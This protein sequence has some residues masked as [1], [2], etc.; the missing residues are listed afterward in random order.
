MSALP[1]TRELRALDVVEAVPAGCF[2]LLVMGE[3]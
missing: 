1:A 3:A 2:A